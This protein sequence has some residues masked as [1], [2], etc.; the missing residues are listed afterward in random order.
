M[1]KLLIMAYMGTGK[2]E[3]ENNYANVVDFDFQDY[4]YIYDESIRHL[5]LEQRKGSTNLRT[6][7][8]N[9]PKNFLDDAKKLLNEGKIV[10]SPFID[11]VFEAYDSSNIK[12]QINDLRIILVCPER[13]NFNEYIERFKNRGNSSEFIARRENE[14]SSLMD[15]FDNSNNYEKIVMKPEQF[16]SE[17]LEEYGITLNKK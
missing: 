14:F 9:Y 7:N 2:T 3:L 10:V 12:S 5:P 6:E 16:L 15:I 13:D 11:H 4:K 8:P 1:D 17:A